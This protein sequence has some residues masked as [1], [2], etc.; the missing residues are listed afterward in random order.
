VL[1]IAAITRAVGVMAAVV[2]NGAWYIYSDITTTTE[3][4]IVNIA[5]A[6]TGAVT[7]TSIVW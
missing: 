5:T 7:A 1:L 4:G 6:A 3:L 2:A